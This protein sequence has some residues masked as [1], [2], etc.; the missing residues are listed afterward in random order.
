MSRSEQVFL[1][2]LAQVS[3]AIEDA[4]ARQGLEFIVEDVSAA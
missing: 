2:R 1:G 4:L 3:T